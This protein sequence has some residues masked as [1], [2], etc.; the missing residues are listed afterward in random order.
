KQKQ[1][2]QTQQ[3]T[4]GTPPRPGTTTPGTTPQP[5]GQGAT[6]PGQP[7]TRE[8]ALGDLSQRVRI[9]TPSLVGSISLKGARI[10]DLS[11][12]TYRETVDPNSA[13]IVRLAPSGSPPRFY[14]EFGWSAPP[15]P[16]G[17]EP[18]KVPGPDT[19]WRQQGSGALAVG[20]PVTLSYDNGEGLEFRRTIA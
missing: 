17:S 16:K 9:D 12:V 15:A 20:Q 14:A 2:Q 4:P 19:L 8:A 1:Q 5:P 10:D 6:T 7:M 11:L 13:P 18:L 3:Q